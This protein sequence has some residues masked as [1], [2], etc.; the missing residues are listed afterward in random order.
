MR[1][2]STSTWSDNN[3][4]AVGS[5]TAVGIV[6][7]NTLAAGSCMSSCTKVVD[8]TSIVAADNSNSSAA[9]GTAFGNYLNTDSGCTS[10]PDNK[11]KPEH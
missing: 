10:A 6:G 11:N 5:S 7:S 2:S 9:D 3:T 4:A 1:R 8:S